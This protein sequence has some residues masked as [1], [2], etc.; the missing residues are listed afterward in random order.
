MDPTSP[1]LAPDLA[2]RSVGPF[3]IDLLSELH[4]LSFAESWD[5]PWSPQSFADVLG[6]PGAAG[7]IA[8]WQGEPIGFGLTLAAADEVELLLLAILPAH[9]GRK[10]AGRLLEAL[11]QAAAA[12]GAR[13]A[14]LEVA[15]VNTPA[16]ACYARAG[17]TP[18]GHRKAYYA[19]RIDALIFER[20]INLPGIN[21]KVDT[22]R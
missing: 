1:R 6:M 9:R 22:E 10:S 21:A 18:C 3:D 13:R 2:F 14:V 5:Q 8:V 7:L 20:A 17:F 15:A 4:R 16:I 19:G 11:L 12:G